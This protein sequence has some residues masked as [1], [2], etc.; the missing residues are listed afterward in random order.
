MTD[1]P[2][3]DKERLAEAAAVLRQV[4]VQCRDE[5]RYGWGG[6]AG[7]VLDSMRLELDLAIDRKVTRPHDVGWAKVFGDQLAFPDLM[8]AYYGYQNAARAGMKPEQFWESPYLGL[9]LQADG[10]LSPRI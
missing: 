8:S 7:R 5:N 6:L 1:W 2:N 9:Y 10:T 4:L 3:I